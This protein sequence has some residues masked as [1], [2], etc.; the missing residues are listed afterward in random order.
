MSRMAE[1]GPRTVGAVDVFVVTY[2]PD[3][4]LL[5]QLI[6]ALANQQAHGFDAVH[7]HVWDNSTDPGRR[8]ALRDF[9]DARKTLLS[10]VHLH[11][12]GRNLGFGQ[13]NNRL[14][15]LSGAP[16]IL[17]LNQD[18]VPEAD[19]LA[20]LSEHV[21][22]DPAEVGVWELR[23]IPYEHPKI[24][25]PSSLETPWVSGAACLLRRE[26]F[27]AVGGFDPRI[28]MY[29][30]DVDLSW[31][32]RAEGWSL[33]YVPQ[34]AVFHDTY[35]RPS[36]EKPLQAVEGTLTNLKLRARFGR[37]RD[38]ATGVL[39]VIREVMRPASFPGRRRRFLSLLPRFLRQLPAFRR[40]GRPYRG[41]FQ[42]VFNGWDFSLRRDGPFFPFRRRA[43]WQS[44][45]LVSIIVR[46]H[47]RPA[48]LREALQ[49]L[50][51]QT[52]PN[53]EIVV[54]E[55][56]E[57]TA[58]RMVEDEFSGHP[59]LRY[60]ATGTPVGRSRAGNLGLERAQGEWLGFLDDDDQIFADHVEVLLQTA[61]DSGV[62]GAYGIAWEVVT[63]VISREP[64]EYVE[65]QHNARH[66]Q[67]FSRPLLW[68]HNFIP[69]QSA[70]FH[71]SLYEQHGG[72]A[73][74]MD[75]LEDWNLWTRYTLHDDFVLVEK[76]TSK[77]RVPSCPQHSA[78]RQQKLDHAYAQALERQRELSITVSP[79]DFME[80]AEDYVRCNS[81]VVVTQG[82]V[83]GWIERLGAMQLAR[84]V[85]QKLRGM[86]RA[87]PV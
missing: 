5:G 81:V 45:P 40:T 3:E 73:E 24:Y 52:Y 17:L 46:T 65:R 57:D 49:S 4:G 61:L 66:R 11:S 33:H 16:W 50:V 28:F 55:D 84:R 27:E 71:R 44:L 58:R 69:I 47:R 38:V 75:Q 59:R 78:E 68:H 51:H 18:A 64:L 22:Q 42:P 31:R 36:E 62:K 2:D 9:L 19:A 8:D 54:V 32:L 14:A 12:E 77:Y 10:S 39:G 7:L 79:R 20:V 34:A 72:F 25:D 15:A 23:Q 80:M 43:E 60:F 6:A 30:E 56:G 35:S 74:D 82:D 70:L 41:R 53:V 21:R 83:R 67:R 29:A 63:D 86:R 37:W 87:R 26:A 13:G 1:S 48:M 76:T 85:L